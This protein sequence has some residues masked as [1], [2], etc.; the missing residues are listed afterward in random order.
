MI[1][2]ASLWLSLIMVAM[3]FVHNV[4][5]LTG[6][7]LLQ[8][9]LSGFQSAVITLVATQTP[10]ERAGWALGVIFSGQVGGTL[11]GPLFGGYLAEVIGFRENFI[12]IGMLCFVAFILTLLF[13]KEEQICTSTQDLKFR[14][15]WHLIP[16]PQMAIGLLLTTLVMQL[17]LMSVQPIIT[18]YI[19][20]LVAPGTLHIAFISGAVFAASGLASILAAPKLGRIS[21]QVGP[22]K[23]LLIALIVA[24]ITFI[25]QAFVEN[26]WQLGLLRFLLGVATAGLLPSVNNLIKQSTPDCITGRAFGYMQSA[27]FSGMFLGSILGGQLAASFGIQ[28][29]FYFTGAVLLLNAFWVYRTIY[30]VV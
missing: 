10:K 25:P 3:G 20:Q 15:F 17:A 14:E 8:G 16:K 13:V 19:T 18:I 30:K 23:V 26:Y 1:L 22:H 21:D 29:V 12:A 6:L 28:C 2:R 7:R 11:L 27:Q 24:G 4:Y 9:A 5:Q